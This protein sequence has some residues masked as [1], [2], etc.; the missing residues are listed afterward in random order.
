MGPLAHH[1]PSARLLAVR[2]VVAAAVTA[3]LG[4]V[5]A[6][7]EAAPALLAWGR[8]G[9]RPGRPGGH[10]PQAGGPAPHRDD[11]LGHRGREAGP[12][13][14]DLPAPTVR[15]I[16]RSLSRDQTTLAVAAVRTV[17]ARTMPQ[18]DGAA[19]LAESVAPEP[20]LPS[21]QDLTDRADAVLATAAELRPDQEDLV[22]R[23]DVGASFG[24]D[25][26]AWGDPARQAL[27]LIDEA[28][29]L[30]SG[31]EAAMAASGVPTAQDEADVTQAESLIAQGRALATEAFDTWSAAN[32]S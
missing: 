23:A 19:A 16:T 1:R 14:L 29:A 12:G 25:T 10:R 2:L 31:A 11:Q 9:G 8:R 20:A 24:F 6:P 30:A 7:A 22:G 21:Q 26:S 18:V 13:D 3:G 17:T 27:A 5:A 4:A 32:A 15:T 28:V